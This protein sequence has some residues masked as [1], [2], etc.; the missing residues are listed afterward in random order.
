M[1]R[2]LREVR[3]NPVGTGPLKFRDWKKDQYVAFTA[4]ENYFLGRPNFRSLTSHRA[5]RSGM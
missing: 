5:R 3:W 1:Q 2:A 4:H